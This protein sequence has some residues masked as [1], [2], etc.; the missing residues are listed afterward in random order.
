MLT[1]FGISPCLELMFGDLN[2]WARAFMG[3]FDEKQLQIFQ[4]PPGGLKELRLIV[5]GVFLVI[6]HVVDSNF[7]P[8]IGSFGFCSEVLAGESWGLEKIYRD[9]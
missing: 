1:I 2:E 8:E 6:F 9:T 4:S 3:R 7:Y 5:S